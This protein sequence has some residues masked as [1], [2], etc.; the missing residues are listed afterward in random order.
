MLLEQMRFFFGDERGNPNRRFEPARANLFEHRLNITA[1]CSAGFEPVTHRR[2]IAVVD[3]DVLQAGRVL[4]D[5]IKVI[6]YLLC[7]DTR[8][9]AVPG[10]PAGRRSSRSQGRMN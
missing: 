9:E 1:E 10:T 4:C 7:R 3:L 5:E 6:L 2:L 8:T